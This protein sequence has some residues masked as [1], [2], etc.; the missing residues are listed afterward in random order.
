MTAPTRTDM[1]TNGPTPRR[2]PLLEALD[3]QLS[4]VF[5]YDLVIAVVGAIGGALRWA[6]EPS[7]PGA[8]VGVAAGLVGVVIGT[9]IA[10]A[11]L[12]AAFMDRP[13]LLK[14]RLLGTRPSYFLGPTLYTGVLGVFGA[15][16]AVTLLALPA[17]LPTW[18]A[19]SA[20]GITGFFVMYTIAS[21]IPVLRMIVELTDLKAAAALIA[22]D[23]PRLDP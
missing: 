8:I 11:A 1:A 12:Q 23:D 5:S 19:A 9:V 22:D 7:D 20:G 4:E 10:A 14:L 3:H 15:I 17:D 18:L 21:L 2:R 13:F 6:N 16:S